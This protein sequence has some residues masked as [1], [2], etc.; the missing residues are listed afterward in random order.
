MSI[1]NLEW[2]ISHV[3]ASSY[4]VENTSLCSNAENNCPVIIIISTKIFIQR[5]LYEDWAYYA[6]SK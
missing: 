2:K 6:N 3:H 5:F 1:A 4:K